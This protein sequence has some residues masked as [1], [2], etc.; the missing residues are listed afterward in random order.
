MV[1]DAEASCCAQA[2][3]QCTR[4]KVVLRKAVAHDMRLHA[5][6]RCPGLSEAARAELCQ[7]EATYDQQYP[8]S[9]RLKQR[10][11][12][13]GAARLDADQSKSSRPAAPQQQGST[14]TSA[15][16]TRPPKQRKL[17]EFYG[18]TASSDAASGRVQQADE[19]WTAYVIDCQRPFTDAEHPSLRRFTQMLWPDYTPPGVLYCSVA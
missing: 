14:S 12:S 7:Q 18:P 1:L 4:C 13:S 6:L 16:D 8:P 19:A 5:E 10:S 9:N 11:G 3:M 15:P 2:D 17:A